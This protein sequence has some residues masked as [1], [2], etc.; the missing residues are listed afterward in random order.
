[1]G[2]RAYEAKT[3][4]QNQTEVRIQRNNF[5]GQW[6]DVPSNELAPDACVEVINACAQPEILEPREGMEQIL[7]LGIPGAFTSYASSKSG[8]TV[9]MTGRTTAA[10][11]INKWISYTSGD[12]PDLITAVAGANSYTVSDNHVVTAGTYGIIR[13]QIHGWMYHR[14]LNLFLIHIGQNLYT[15]TYPAPYSTTLMIQT[16]ET[17]LPNS[18]SHM[19]ELGDEALI[20]CQ[21][22]FKVSVS[23]NHYWKTNVDPAANGLTNQAQSNSGYFRNYLYTMTRLSGTTRLWHDRSSLF[24]QQETGSNLLNNQNIDYTSI[25]TN[26]RQAGDLTTTYQYLQTGASPTLANITGNNLYFNVT[27][28]GN[29]W[30]ISYSTAA[31]ANY[32]QV[33]QA[34]QTAMIQ[35]IGPNILVQ[36]VSGHFTI[37][38]IVA[39]STISY[40]ST[41]AAV[42]GWTDVSSLLLGTSGTGAMIGSF[43]YYSQPDMPGYLVNQYWKAFTHFSFYQTRQ[44]QNNG[45]QIVGNSAAYAWMADVPI[46]K[47]AHGSAAGVTLT[48]TQGAFINF[49]YGTYVTAIYFTGSIWQAQQRRIIGINGS[50]TATI[51]TTIGSLSDP[52]YYFVGADW[53]FVGTV[54]SGIVS[55]STWLSTSNL[56]QNYTAATTTQ[57]VSVGDPV[58]A[59]N[60]EVYW[61]TAVAS[62]TSFT[63]D[64]LSV[65]LG[66]TAFGFTPKSS[67]SGI[68]TRNYTRDQVADAVVSS[69]IGTLGLQTRFYTA[70]PATNVGVVAPGYMVTGLDNKFMWN[71]ISTDKQ[72]LIG[73]CH[74]AYQVQNIVGSITAFSLNSVMVTI[75]TKTSTLVTGT[76]LNLTFTDLNNGNVIA[77]LPPA[78]VVDLYNGALDDR[79]VFN[80]ERDLT[81][82][83]GQDFGVRTWNGYTYS[84]NL[85]FRKIQKLL[86]QLKVM[87]ITYDG[88]YGVMIFGSDRSAIRPF[89]KVYTLG[90][91]EDKYL[92]CSE[93]QQLPYPDLDAAPLNVLG[94]VIYFPLGYCNSWS[95]GLGATW[96]QDS[97]LDVP[98]STA[99]TVGRSISWSMITSDDVATDQ[100]ITLRHLESHVYVSGRGTFQTVPSAVTINTQIYN[101]IGKYVTQNRVLK[102]FPLYRADINFDRRIEGNQIRH[103]L[104]FDSAYLVLNGISAYYVSYDKAA[105]PAD[106]VTTESTWQAEVGTL[107]NWITRIY[108]EVDVVTG[109]QL[110]AHGT[111]SRV[112]GPDGRTGTGYST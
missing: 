45:G 25:Y 3:R 58:F 80:F 89:N 68:Y 33:A 60:G 98:D 112:T 86:E 21:G 40:L 73:N 15:I 107:S 41:P 17:A 10:A 83:I 9:T 66:T 67:T 77:I 24:I 29:L 88:K 69:R 105:A 35:T 93:F 72:Y 8:T 103:G 30:T 92:G 109:Q 110:Q 2:R 42:V 7:A 99:P 16:G 1:V 79:H 76:N 39:L 62:N 111:I 46:M 56:T 6:S 27:V 74:P 52:V 100:A 63:L 14:D 22:I 57:T 96:L 90:V 82:V 59:P 11:D 64:N 106:N 31:T 43:A 94:R 71:D 49:D 51:D 65:N 5:T 47:T 38:E 48:L 91:R 44:L 37:R 28:D 81:V 55:V 108:Q 102:S 13:P 32:N 26:T 70:M 50:T 97:Y 78:Q 34:I 101:D 12:E 53:G 104:T 87:Q 61:V 84:K 54:T 85:V 23:D 95:D 75:Y 20:F 19:V 18:R 36:Y 4:Q